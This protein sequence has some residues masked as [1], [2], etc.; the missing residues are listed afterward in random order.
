[1]K[2]RRSLLLLMKAMNQMRSLLLKL[3]K[4]LSIIMNKL[5]WPTQHTHHTHNTPSIHS[6]T[7]THSNSSSLNQTDTKLFH[8]CIHNPTPV[9]HTYLIHPPPGCLSTRVHEIHIQIHINRTPSPHVKNT[10]KKNQ[11]CKARYTL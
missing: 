10:K 6:W 9:H 3:R 2:Q 1:M 8:I 5:A 11:M 4:Q 7:N